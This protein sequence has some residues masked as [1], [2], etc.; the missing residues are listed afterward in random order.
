L[1]IIY[2]LLLT[3]ERVTTEHVANWSI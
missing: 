2:I 3:E 1:F